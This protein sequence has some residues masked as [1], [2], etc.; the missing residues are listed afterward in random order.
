MRVRKIAALIAL[1]AVAALVLAGCGGKIEEKPAVVVTVAS[2]AQ[3][4]PLGPEA[5][6]GEETAG[7]EVFEVVTPPPEEKATEAPEAPPEEK[8]GPIIEP[9]AIADY[10]FEHGELPDNFLTKEEAEALGWDSSRNYLSD[11]APG[12]SIGGDRFGN[13]EGKLPKAKGRTFREADA[14]YT[15]GKRNG[16]RIV[17][18]SDGRVWYTDDHYETFTELFPSEK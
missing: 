15:G 3:K 9:Q 1:L 6:A 12:M 8:S 16:E 13:Y 18:S 11:V 7:D 2:E 14:N 5:P 4:L 10:L 17:Y